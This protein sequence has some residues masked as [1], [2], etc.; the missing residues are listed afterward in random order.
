MLYRAAG[1]DPEHVIRIGLATSRDGMHFDRADNSPVLSPSQEGP[2]SGAIEDPRIVKFGDV[3]YV[4]YAFRP[5]PPG[6]HPA[7]SP[8]RVPMS[9]PSKGKHCVATDI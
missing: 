4:T 1:E 2:D 8:R 7:L 6:R 5:F 3:F 9:R